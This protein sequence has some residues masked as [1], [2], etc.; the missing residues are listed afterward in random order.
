MRMSAD[1][2]LPFEFLLTPAL[3]GGG[4]VRSQRHPPNASNRLPTVFASFTAPPRL[5]PGPASNSFFLT[6]SI[7]IT[8]PPR[9]H[10]TL[11]LQIPEFCHDGQRLRQRVHENFSL[12]EIHYKAV[13]KPIGAQD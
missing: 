9:K 13:R 8:S 10:L 1:A 2:M 4:S 12:A 11:I 3:L 6:F 7:S 5:L